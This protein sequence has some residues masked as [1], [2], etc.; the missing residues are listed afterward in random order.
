MRVAQRFAGG[1][2]VVGPVLADGAVDRGR[3]DAR[4]PQRLHRLGLV[5]ALLAP[6]PLGE[7]VA[8]GGELVVGQSVELVGLFDHDPQ[9]TRVAINPA[10]R[11]RLSALRSRLARPA[12]P[13]PTPPEPAAAPPLDREAVDNRHF[14]LLLGFLL[15]EDSN[16]VDVGANQGRF[17]HHIRRLAPRGRHFAWEPVP[18]LAA[19]LRE[20][21]PEIEVHEAAVGDAASAETSFIEVKDDPAYSGLRARAYPGDYGPRRS[22]CASS[23][24]TTSSPPATCRR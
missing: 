14:E 18:H 22:R 21:F 2:Q 4:A 20:T 6:Q 17:L 12:P 13:A 9:G 24:W 16:C 1:Q 7:G 3:R 15:A 5:A 23:A 19:L 8:G 10:M 11:E